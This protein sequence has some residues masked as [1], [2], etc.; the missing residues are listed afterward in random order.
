MKGTFF[1]LSK[2]QLTRLRAMEANMKNKT[3]ILFKN[4]IFAVHLSRKKLILIRT[5]TK[6]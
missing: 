2:S 4:I 3:K 1:L 5:T 6:K